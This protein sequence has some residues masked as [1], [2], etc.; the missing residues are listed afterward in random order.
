MAP[1]LTC[2]A[3]EKEEHISKNKTSTTIDKSNRSIAIDKGA[4]QFTPLITQLTAIHEAATDDPLINQVLR[5]LPEEALTR[6]VLNEES[7]RRCFYKVR[8]WCRRVAMIGDNGTSPW[9]HLLSYFQSFLIRSTLEKKENLSTW[10][11][12]TL[13]I[14]LRVQIITCALGIDLELAERDW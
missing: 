8:R 2:E 10:K 14:S 11:M 5:S 1:S 9:T 6:G 12:Q 7:V 4:E 13:P 3:L